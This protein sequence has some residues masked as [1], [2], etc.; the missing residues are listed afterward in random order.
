MS[1]TAVILW[2]TKEKIL[3]CDFQDS[4]FKTKLFGVGWGGGVGSEFIWRKKNFHGKFLEGV[5]ANMLGIQ[6]LK[7]L[8]KNLHENELNFS[9]FWP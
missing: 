7:T 5:W 3:I 1:L 2:N 6:V 9:L 8:E 4:F